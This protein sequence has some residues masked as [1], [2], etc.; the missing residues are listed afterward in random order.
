MAVAV[1]V[2]VS[3]GVGVAVG[4][5]VGVGVDVGIAVVGEGGESPERTLRARR[6]RDRARDVPAR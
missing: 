3:V 5:A 2:G 1:A 6:R 4:V